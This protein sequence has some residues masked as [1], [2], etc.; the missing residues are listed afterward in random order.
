MAS[1]LWE[2]LA[3]PAGL[4][5]PARVRTDSGERS[6]SDRGKSS[7]GSPSGQRQPGVAQPTPGNNSSSSSPS[8]SYNAEQQ[9]R[10]TQPV[11]TSSTFEAAPS[12]SRIAD[13]MPALLDAHGREAQSQ[14]LSPLT[15][16]LLAGALPA[17][18][19]HIDWRLLYSTAVHGISLN[20][21]YAK[22]S[23][24][25][26][27]LLAI[28][29]DAGHIFGGFCTEWREPVTPPAFYGGGETFLFAVDDQGG[30][31]AGGEAGVR[32]YPWSGDNSFFMFSHRDHLA[33]G[34]GGHFGLYLDAELLHGSSGP[35]ETFGNE[36]LC[37]P[38]HGS[39]GGGRRDDELPV[40]EFRC[41]VL[42][43]WGMDHSMISRRQQEVML[44]GLR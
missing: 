16:R 38:K 30:A 24:C 12:A 22:T 15:I 23:G 44:R 5:S 8:A 34:S 25:G 29:D 33:I 19:V 43:V 26:C 36:C 7:P 10:P 28:K 32:L 20:T 9:Q 35:C 40:G 41:A 11:P 18:F 14:I 3:S 21:F 39:G 31:S 42:E 27:C 6:P 1:G 37:R 2:L 17:R 13:A 4:L